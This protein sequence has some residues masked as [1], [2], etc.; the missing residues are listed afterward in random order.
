MRTLHRTLIAGVLAGAVVHGAGAQRGAPPSRGTSGAPGNKQRLQTPAK[1]DTTKRQA[2]TGVMLDFEE[3]DLKVVLNALAAAGN[4]NVILTNIPSERVTVHMG[5]PVSRDS[6]AVVLHSLA[7]AHNLKFTQ[8]PTLIQI[9]GPTPQPVQRGPT[10]Q[11]LFAQQ[12]AAQNQQQA[13]RLFTYRLHHASAVQL[14]PVLTSLFIGASTTFPTR[15]AFPNGNG[16]FTTITTP[17]N[18]NVIPPAI[19]GNVGR[20]ARGGIVGNGGGLGNG[21]NG[22]NGING[23]NPNAQIQ[24]ALVNAF[25]QASGALSSQSGDI[26]I[27]AEESSNSL[28]VRATDSDWQLIQAIIQGVDL[29]PLQ[30][31]IEVTIAEVQRTH[32]LD[33]GVSGGLRKTNGS[34][35]AFDSSSAPTQASARDFILQ[36]TGGHGTINYNVAIAALQERGNVRVLS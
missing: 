1:Q 12:L 27:I 11:E 14:A 17:G 4:L 7:E 6:M 13:V 22:N 24:N 26:R 20:G 36:L 34:K 18:I 30:V 16:G 21:N 23:N 31:L 25:A 2:P 3:Q 15:A 35:V 33:I 32:D 28:L 9:A 29:R 8:S 10:A 5:Q 19:Q